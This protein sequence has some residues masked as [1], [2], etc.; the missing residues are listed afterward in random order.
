MWVTCLFSNLC[1]FGGRCREFKTFKLPFTHTS[2]Y[3]FKVV[4]AN[5]MDRSEEVQMKVLD[6]RSPEA[7]LMCHNIIGINLLNHSLSTT[8]GHYVILL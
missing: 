7:Y 8:L 3:T 5:C 6:S 4:F 2:G 1:R